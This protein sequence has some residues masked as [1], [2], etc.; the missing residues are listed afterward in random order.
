MRRPTHE[1]DNADSNTALVQSGVSK[2][3]SAPAFPYA[4]VEIRFES[5]NE[6]VGTDNVRKRQMRYQRVADGT[7][8]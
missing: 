4:A 1:S 8:P 3:P 2:K 5:R 7:L 6:F